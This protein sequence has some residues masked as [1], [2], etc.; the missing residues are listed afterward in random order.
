MKIAC[1]NVDVDPL[2]C[3]YAIHGLDASAIDDDPVYSNGIGRFLELFDKYSI[4]GTFFITAH[5]FNAK[6]TAVLKEIKERGHEIAD[7]SF[8][9]NYQL[10]R[11]PKDE[12][13]KEIKQNF[14]F[15][16]EAAG[17]TCKG[18]RSP[19]YNSNADLISV[20]KSVG[21]IYD[22]SLFPSFS[23]Y[24]AK[25]ILINLKKL[26]GHNSKSIISSFADAFG[27][28]TPEFIDKTVRDTQKSGTFAELPMTTLIPLAGIP[29]IGTSIITFPAFLIDFMLKISKTR[30]FINIEAHGI[31]MCD[32]DESQYF[33]A[34][35]G[36]QPDLAFSLDRKIEKFSRVI[37][38]YKNSGFTFKTLCEVAEMKLNGLFNNT[39]ME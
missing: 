5:G 38:F 33:S 22:S 10:T 4:K 20:L 9:H 31:D 24:V 35:K 18:F 19:G 14:D 11:L 26:S 15:L 39:K 7:H 27:R 2:V 16:N 37:E 34:L 28:Y 29:L 21:Y 32:A 30:S 23:Y 36:K 1:I 12:I 13:Y 8:S 25:W 3:Y 17:V 6:N